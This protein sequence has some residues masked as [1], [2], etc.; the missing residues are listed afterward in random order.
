MKKDYIFKQK[1]LIKRVTLLYTYAN[2]YCLLDSH[3][4]FFIQSVAIYCFL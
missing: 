2:L 1:K 4:C 3:I